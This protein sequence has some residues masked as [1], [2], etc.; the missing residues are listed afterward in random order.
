M[1][2]PIYSFVKSY[3]ESGIS[4][5]HM[6]GHKGRAFIGCENLD[7]TEIRGADELYDPCGIIEQSKKNAASLFGTRA[8]FYSAEG[9][10]LCIRAMLYLASQ[11]RKI[12]SERPVFAALSGAHKVF[13]FACAA[14]DADVLFLN[15]SG[16][17]TDIFGGGFNA[18]NLEKKLENA[19]ENLC[20]LYITSPNYLGRICDIAR[21]KSICKKKHIPLIVDN[22][23][24]AYLKFLPSGSMHPMD[25]GADMCCDSAHK[26]LP[27]LTGGAY[28]HISRGCEW[29]FEK[30]AAEA[31]S[32][33][34]STSPSYLILSSLDLANRYIS[35]SIMSDTAKICDIT[36]ELKQKIANIG[37]DEVSDEP[38]KVTLKP[39]SFGYTGDGIAEILRKNGIEPEFSDPD[40]VVLMFSPL[41]DVSDADKVFDVLSL[42]KRRSRITESAPPVIHGKRVM[43]VRSALFS[44]KENIPVKNASGRILASACVGCP[45]AIPVAVCGETINQSVISAFK[46]YGIEQVNVVKKD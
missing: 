27:V 17:E 42:L 26:T 31:L 21:L 16:K 38:L 1:D 10:S 30:G 7:I 15:Q 35:E 8:T 11:T 34:G 3:S 22:A 25:L 9:S 36:A 29:D 4:R 14:L 28:L 6:P 41:S 13:M 39:K 12:K 44:S 24:G 2:T 43:S 20:A 18:E 33:F 45:P 37:F 23:H 46:Y 32:V 19:P 40:Y 5:L